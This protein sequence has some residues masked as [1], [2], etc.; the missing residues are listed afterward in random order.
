MES[1]GPGSQVF[2][3]CLL[4]ECR[5]LQDA[6]CDTHTCGVLMQSNFVSHMNVLSL[7]E[8]SGGVVVNVDSPSWIA[9]PP[10]RVC[11]CHNSDAS[12]K[13]YAACVMI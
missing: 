8:G 9:P 12:S 10:R 11:H 4:M 3:G 5:N 2:D 6:S 13:Q 7:P 1:K